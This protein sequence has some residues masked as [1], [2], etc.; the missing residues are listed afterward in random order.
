ML[1]HSWR[2]L[3][4]GDPLRLLRLLLFPGGTA[5]EPLPQ[6]CVQPVFEP[7]PVPLPHCPTEARSHVVRGVE[8]RLGRKLLHNRNCDAEPCGKPCN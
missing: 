4:L 5:V 8:L 2:R 1:R 7:P 6:S 3:R